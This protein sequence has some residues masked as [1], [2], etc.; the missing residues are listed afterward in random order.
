MG[1]YAG[2]DV[3][4]ASVRIGRLDAW[5]VRPVVVVSARESGDLFVCPVSSSPSFDGPS[6]PISL[7]DF[8]RGG[9]DLFGESYA[10]TAYA[11]TIRPA[12]VVAKKGTLL[13]G[14]LAAIRETL[15]ERD[16]SPQRK[17]HRR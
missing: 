15:P 16:R 1:H 12:D 9:L 2:G 6:V 3:L 5:K 17:P 7:E 8:A 4:L 11:S 13:P 10:L 14:T